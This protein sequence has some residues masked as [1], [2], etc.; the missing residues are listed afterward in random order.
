MHILSAAQIKAC[1]QHT[2]THEPIRSR[3]LMERA[4]QRLAEALC[5]LIPAARAY[6]VFCGPGN[7][8]GDGLVLARHLHGHGLAVQVYILP[9]P[10][11]AEIEHNRARLQA[12]GLNCTEIVGEVPALQ[13]P[14]DAIAV[15]ALYGIGLS[16]PLAGLAAE[17]VRG[18]NALE[19]TVVALDLPSG[20]SADAL[21]T[22]TADNTVC[23][24]YTL[25]VQLPKLAFFF[26][27]NALFVGQF[28][29]VDIGLSSACIVAQTS[30]PVYVEDADIQALIRPRPRYAHKGTFGH[31]L[32]LA[33]SE[34]KVG[35]ALLASKA[36][37][38]SGCGRVTVSLPSEATT[39]L[40][41]YVPE[42]MV[43]PSA[44]WETTDLAAYEAMG[45]GPGM[46]TDAR[47]VARIWHVLN[48]RVQAT[49]ID[50]DGL[51]ILAQHPHWYNRLGPHIVLTPHPKEFDR[52][53][54]AHNSGAERYQTQVAFARQHRVTV[55]L[56][57]HYSSIVTHSGQSYFNSTGNDGM[58]TAGTGDVLTGILAA[59]LAQGYSPEHAAVL[60]VYL[61]GYAGDLA[62]AKHSRT[63]MIASDT[64]EELGHFFQRFERP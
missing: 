36:A 44:L 51:T 45:V 59:L 5:Q 46:G 21:H 34:G 14:A 60:G 15:D 8:G 41:S 17:L 4:G 19:H 2:I 43:L 38:R 10:Y 13:V 24:D 50:A 3:D 53:T 63:A 23:A 1:D 42:A 12:L 48:T 39:A 58:A 47:A 61:H 55:V 29:C 56:K 30:A 64:I 32:L 62:A 6:V 27:E 18:I 35:A 54:R 22:S 31:S 7:N 52:L 57:G 9:G 40:N 33:G 49:V 11:S 28:S 20:L 16:R 25:S 37:L 26:A